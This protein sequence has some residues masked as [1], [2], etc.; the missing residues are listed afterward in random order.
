[1]VKPVRP[2]VAKTSYVLLPVAHATGTSKSLETGSGDDAGSA[3]SV[4]KNGPRQQ[5]LHA[6]QEGKYIQMICMDL[7]NP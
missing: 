4:G 6:G 2:V 3:R 1:M 5:V 7:Q